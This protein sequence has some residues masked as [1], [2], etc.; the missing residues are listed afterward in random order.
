MFISGICNTVKSFNKIKELQYYMSCTYHDPHS[1]G[2]G[3][4]YEDYHATIRH[5]A[6]Q[7]NSLRFVVD[8]TSFFQSL[9]NINFSKLKS[10]GIKF[11]AKDIDKMFMDINNYE[12][13][14]FRN[15]TNVEELSIEAD[16]IDHYC[17]NWIVE[18]FPN[19]RQIMFDLTTELNSDYLL[20]LYS[21][22]LLMKLKSITWVY[23]DHCS[24]LEPIQNW[25]NRTKQQLEYPCETLPELLKYTIYN[26]LNENNKY[27]QLKIC[28]KKLQ[29]KKAQLNSSSS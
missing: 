2:I 25:C 21:S 18:S 29:Q 22:P 5:M 13:K 24:N 14:K 17:I 7:L 20:T 1:L 28:R 19:I 4:V 9:N 11:N 23:H 16:D 6:P 26:E 8:K 3:G 10:L 27:V 12:S 15:F